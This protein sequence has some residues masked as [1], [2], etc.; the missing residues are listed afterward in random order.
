MAPVRRLA[1]CR[2]PSYTVCVPIAKKI[3]ANV[4]PE[5]AALLERAYA[6]DSDAASRAL[7]RDWAETYDTTM[8]DGLRYLSPATVAQLLDAHLSE[9]A[10]PVLDVGCGTGLAGQSLFERGFTTIDGLDL[11]PEMVQVAAR[12]G[13]YR[14]FISADLHQTLPMADASYGGAMGSGIFT[15]GHVDARCLDELF[16]VLRPG[17][18]FAFTVKLEVW[19]PLG[20]K[21]KLAGLMAC[22]SITELAFTHDRHYENSAQP[23]GVFCVY[24]RV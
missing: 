22:G 7:Y 1:R 13:V 9:C 10:A 24:R 18:P 20:F 21:D 2:S 19:E 5:A 11:S 6:I 14:A 3:P 4:S 12:R 23:D 15:H 16:R 8:I 17:A